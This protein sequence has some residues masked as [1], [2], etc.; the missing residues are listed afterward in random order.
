[1]KSDRDEKIPQ[2]NLAQANLS[3][4]E[5]NPDNW[6][7]IGLPQKGKS[8]S[9]GLFLVPFDFE[10]KQK[11]PFKLKEKAPLYI[12]EFGG[13][14][15][16]LDGEKEKRLTGLKNWGLVERKIFRENQPVLP[17]GREEWPRKE[18]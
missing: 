12:F 4:F 11:L 10:V 8:Y 2:L 7:I 5:F 1:L 9:A 18:R 16:L 14:G 17:F 3:A 13:G 6:Q 15:A